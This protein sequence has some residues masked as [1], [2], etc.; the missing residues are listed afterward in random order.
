[1]SNPDLPSI[2]EITRGKIKISPRF[3]DL[4]TLEFIRTGKMTWGERVA[5]QTVLERHG[6]DKATTVFM[7]ILETIPAKQKF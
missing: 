4:V 3:F 1:M 7:R 5:I 6:V 2:G